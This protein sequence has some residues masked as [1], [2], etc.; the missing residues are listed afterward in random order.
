MSSESPAADAAHGA[1]NEEVAPR[2]P[3]VLRIV[4]ALEVI[5]AAGL[6]GLIVFGVVLQILGRFFPAIRWIGAGE[7][8]LLAMIALTFVTTG[9]LVGRNG[10]I[11]IEVFDAALKGKWLF[12]ALRVVSALI[13][14]V[15]SAAL[16]NEAYAKM[17]GEWARTSAAMQIPLGIIYIFA[18]L[19][20][21]S[22]AVHSAWKIPTANKP[23]RHLEISE[24]DG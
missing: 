23:E 24:M 16:V 15:T 10:H 6:F 3:K 12:V 4:S 20:F 13:M 17:I 7:L 1:P 11:V 8:A 9:Y 18:V 19:G 2:E 22:A 21:A 14:V 5:Q